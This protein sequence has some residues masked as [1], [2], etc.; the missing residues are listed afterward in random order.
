MNAPDARAA[1]EV[2]ALLRDVTQA[3]IGLGRAGNSLPTDRK[4]VV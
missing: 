4:S 2:W 3:R 1:D